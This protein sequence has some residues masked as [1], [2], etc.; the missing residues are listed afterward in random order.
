MRKEATEL[1]KFGHLN[2]VVAFPGSATKMDMS[3]HKIIT[4]R[5]MVLMTRTPG[6]GPRKSSFSKE[7]TRTRAPVAPTKITW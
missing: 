3:A 4:P 1:D 5:P 6:H 7:S 2:V